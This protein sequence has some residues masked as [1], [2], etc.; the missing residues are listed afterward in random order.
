MEAGPVFIIGL[1]FGG[2]RTKEGNG[3]FI[4]IQAKAM[5]KIV[6]YD[7]CLNAAHNAK[8]TQYSLGITYFS[9][10]MHIEQLSV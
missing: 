3:F 6:V 7:S 4:Y 8:L 1:R 9:D 10:L 5:T 2:A